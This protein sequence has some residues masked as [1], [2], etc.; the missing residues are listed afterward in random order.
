L[1]IRSTDDYRKIPI[2]E[3]LCLLETSAEGLSESE[4]RNRIQTFGYN[5]VAEKRSSPILEFLKRYWGPMPWLL[6]SAIVLSYILGHYVEVLMIFVLLTVNAFIGYAHASSSL[7]ALELLKR[8]LAVKAKV[9]RDGSWVVR[10]AREITYGDIIVLGLGDIVPADAKLISGELSVD[11]SALTGES[12]PVDVGASGIVYSSSTVRRGEAKVVVVNVGINTYFGKTAELV[13]IAK[14][15]S[16]QEEVMMAVVKYMMYLGLTAIVPVSTYAM[17]MHRD[18]L[19]ILTFVVVFLMGAVPVALPAVLT[20]VEAVGARELAEKGVLVTKLESI[21]D[22]ASID[23]LC[24]DKTGTITQNRLTVAEVTPLSGFSGK[25]VV[26][27]ASL[28][29]REE[30]KDAIDLAIIECATAAGTHT[31]GC[32]RTSFMPFNPSIKRSE[33]VVEFEGKLFRAVKGAPQV[34]LSMCKGTDRVTREKVEVSL[35][36]LAQ[37]GYRTLAVAKSR[38]NVL[39][40]LQLLGLISL[41]DPPWPDSKSMIEEARSLGLKPIMLTG[42]NVAIAKE[43]ARQVSIGSNIIRI[44]DLQGLPEREQTRLIEENDGFAEIYP[45]DKY[46]IV[47]LLQS[48]GHMVGMTGDGVN[49]APALKQSEMGIAVSN[50]TDVAKASASV[51]LTGSGVKV[52]IDAVKVSRQIYQRM[53][54]WV[55]NKVTKTAQFV[56]LL[57]LGFFWTHDIVISLLGMSL[58]VIAN[59]FTTMSLA[60]DNVKHTGNPNKWNVKSITLTS[61]MIGMMLVVEGAIALFIGR[62]YLSLAWGELCTFLTLMLVFTSQFRVLTLRERK[63]FWSSRPGKG[64]LI[65]VTA[66]TI[67]FVVLGV[68]GVIIPPL[69]LSQVLFILGFSALF[70]LGIDLPKYYAFRRLGL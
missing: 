8:S 58:L 23:V 10:D 57:T 65:S 64:L 28:A 33:A 51:V 45:E 32:R 3:V 31:S 22:A 36:E 52:I 61:L 44:S 6:E 59:D 53:L 67:G 7:E 1:K 40:D 20:I 41:A 2:Q 43:V 35:A 70:T 16:H 9:L 27:V 37:K 19:S 30:G 34:I 56:G 26:R 46:R 21:D 69:A 60:T 18:L 17:L 42:D 66:T 15:R 39:E 62:H 49:D 55:I 48:A 54:T 63:Y 24:L 12:L 14:H 38:D 68:Y 11:Q 47:K 25:D 5:E 13:R 29:S 4:A 50:S